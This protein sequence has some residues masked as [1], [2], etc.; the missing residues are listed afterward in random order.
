MG[1]LVMHVIVSYVQQCSTAWNNCSRLGSLIGCFALQPILDGNS[2]MIFDIKDPR[3]TPASSSYAFEA[4]SFA[5]QG[6]TF[7]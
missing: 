5:D 3:D 2:V 6:Q 1:S 7:S 4:F